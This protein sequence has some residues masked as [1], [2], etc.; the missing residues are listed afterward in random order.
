MLKIKNYELIEDSS[1]KRGL[2]RNKYRNNKNL[3]VFVHGFTGNYLSTWGNFSKLLINDVKLSSCDFL[4]WGYSSNFILPREES[5][6]DNVKQLFTQFLNKHKTNQQIEVVAQGLQTELKYLDQYEN[7]T[8]VG[9]SLGGLVIRSYIIQ[10]LRENNEISQ[11]RIKKI[12]QIILFGTPNEGLDAANNK[13]LGGL[14]NQIHDM[15]TYSQFIDTL[16]EEWIERVFKNRSLNFSSLMIAGEDDYF[17]PFEQ[18]TKHFRDSHELTKGDHFSMVKPKSINDMSY[19]IVAD[20]IYN[21]IKLKWY[22][23]AE[24]YINDHKDY[25]SFYLKRMLDDVKKLLEN[26][27]LDD[28]SWSKSVTSQYFLI[29]LARLLNITTNS[30]YHNLLDLFLKSFYMKVNNSIVLSEDKILVTPEETLRMKECMLEED[31]RDD[32]F[33]RYE[34]TAARNLD[35]DLLQCNY[36]Y[37]LVAQLSRAKEFPNSSTLK[38]IQGLAMQRL[39]YGNGK[40]PIED[41]GGWYPQRLPWVTARILISIKNSGYKDRKDWQEIEK[42]SSKAIN[43]LMRSVY[44]G[45][46]WRSGAGDWVSDLEST[47]LCLEAIEQWGKVS[48]NEANIFPIIRHF[49]DME[50][51]W[52]ENFEFS[53][54]E[55]SNEILASV[56]LLCNLLIIIQN[57]F[58]KEFN[59]DYSK[60]LHYLSK[61]LSSMLTYSNVVV[62]QYNTYPQIAFYITKLVFCLDNSLI[63][64]TLD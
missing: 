12:R 51:E 41:H 33:A 35:S 30:D 48:E 2:F 3:A 57:N 38:L 54:E 53:S 8:L 34:K 62:R 9:H 40:K 5:F 21:L 43:F 61:V 18:V 16:R 47:A 7:I 36:H 29:N 45:K 58:K 15:S 28:S 13:I 19:R 27:G 44:Q 31:R 14:N 52:L 49:L 20:N 25:N 6:V 32:Y 37:G 46:Y 26:R 42:I 22:N 59:L 11:E 4:F 64:K 39:L 60:Y 23:K 24:S 17:V 55:N 10:N 50:E 63:N 1:K 56:T